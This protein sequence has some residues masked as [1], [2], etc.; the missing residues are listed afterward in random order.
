ML[1]ALAF[2]FFVALIGLLH[3][4]ERL[5]HLRVKSSEKDLDSVVGSSAYG[6][7]V[8]Q[9][10]MAKLGVEPDQ[11]RQREDHEFKPFVFGEKSQSNSALE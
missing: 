11:I 4:F 5:K 6:G 9:A 1:F 2:G 3:L 7:L 8:G 10:Y